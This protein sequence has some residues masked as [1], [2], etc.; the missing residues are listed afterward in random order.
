MKRRK[1][2]SNAAVFV[3]MAAPML[4]MA[5][6]VVKNAVGPAQSQVISKWQTPT[7]SEFPFE[8]TLQ[9]GLAPE[10]V[11][12]GFT[13]LVAAD[14]SAIPGTGTITK[15]IPIVQNETITRDLSG[16]KVKIKGLDQDTDLE[17]CAYR[18]TL[19]G[20]NLTL[21]ME[22]GVRCRLASADWPNIR[23]VFRVFAIK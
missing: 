13:G 5:Q 1:W 19:A 8:S 21:R 14:G 3:A 22:P 23:F 2:I 9:L 6:D 11:M 12:V 15:A 18:L 16:I 4:A 10:F 17:P 20:S 7:V